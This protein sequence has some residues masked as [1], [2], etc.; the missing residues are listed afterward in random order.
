M[1]RQN[2]PTAHKNNWLRNLGQAQR[3]VFAWTWHRF[4]AGPTIY[5]SV[6]RSQPPP[7]GFPRSAPGRTRTCD[8]LLRRQMLYPAEL[9]AQ[10]S[11]EPLPARV[12]ARATGRAK[13][14]NL[15]G[16]DSRRRRL[17]RGSR[18]RRYIGRMA[19][20][21]THKST[22]ECP[23]TGPHDVRICGLVAA[24]RQRS[25]DMNA[26]IERQIKEEQDR[27]ARRSAS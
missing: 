1:S 21:T 25:A 22:P 8:I 11:Q 6:R 23:M 26:A 17:S 2:S 12:K 4:R 3:A 16:P 19:D 13:R 24:R 14:A 20:L 10:R 18:G 9:R 15:I 27:A 5:R 7:G